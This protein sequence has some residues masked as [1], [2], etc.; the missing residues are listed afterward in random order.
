MANDWTKFVANKALVAVAQILP[1]CFL[2]DQPWINEDQSTCKSGVT[3]YWENVTRFGGKAG[4]PALLVVP[5]DGV[6]S[7]L[8][9]LVLCLGASRARSQLIDFRCVL[10]AFDVLILIN[11]VRMT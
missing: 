1:V 9:V 10:I 5:G 2:I 7:D 4:D 11:L 6:L 3:R 8:V